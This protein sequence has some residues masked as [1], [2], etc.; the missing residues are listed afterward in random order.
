MKSLLVAEP[1]LMRRGHRG[2]GLEGPARGKTS[3]ARS[4]F[5]PRDCIVLAQSFPCNPPTLQLP[6]N[7]VLARV[8]LLALSLS[9]CGEVWR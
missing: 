2:G 8:R 9:W 6:N 1:L 3:R 5:A 7:A 4:E